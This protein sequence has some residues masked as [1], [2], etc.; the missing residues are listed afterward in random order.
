MN[1]SKGVNLDT[2]TILNQMGTRKNAR[3]NSIVIDFTYAE[4]DLLTL[5]VYLLKEA[6]KTGKPAQKYKEAL[7]SLERKCAA[8]LANK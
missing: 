1:N 2:E 6:H 4:F 7:I 5:S 3:K 8:A